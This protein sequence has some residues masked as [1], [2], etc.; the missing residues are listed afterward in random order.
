MSPTVFVSD[1][2]LKSLAVD[3]S[4]LDATQLS[5]KLVAR[6]AG[7]CTSA[8]G[9]PVVSGSV[10]QAVSHNAGGTRVAVQASVPFT[11]LSTDQQLCVKLGTGGAAEY[12][13]YE[14]VTPALGYIRTGVL[15]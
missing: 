12:V 7:N 4:F 6:G 15:G 1:G 5:F 14:F 9:V 2:V 11:T 3:G 13:W 8:S 10:V